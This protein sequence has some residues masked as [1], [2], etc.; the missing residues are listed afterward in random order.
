M[1]AERITIIVIFVAIIKNAKEISN[2]TFPQE[3]TSRSKISF[4]QVIRPCCVVG[5]HSFTLLDNALNS[6]SNNTIVKIIELNVLL[7]SKISL[8]NL[9]NISIIGHGASTVNCNRIGAINLFYCNNVMIT[10]INWENCGSSNESSLP[11][12]SFYQSHNITIQYCS[13]YSSMGQVLLFSEVSGNIVINSCKFAHNSQYKG[14]GAL[15]IIQ[16]K[17]QILPQQSW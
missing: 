16:L 12:L 15:C 11:V 6:S 2:E 1:L 14:H 17:L 10:G 8:N 9:E 3:A 5:D 7:Q 4:D 13:F